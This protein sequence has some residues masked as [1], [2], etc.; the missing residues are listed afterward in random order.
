[1]FRQYLR[2]GLPIF[3]LLMGSL[4]AT[5]YED[6]TDAN[7]A[8][9]WSIYDNT[10]PN[11]T[12]T[13][14]LDSVTNSQVIEL[15]GDGVNNGYML[16]SFSNTSSWNNTTEYILN[17]D[18]K[19]SS[20]YII[21]VRV[22]TING[23]RYLYYTSSEVSYGQAQG[24]S[25]IHFGLGA[26]SK[27]GEWQHISRNLQ[28]DLMQFEPNNQLL[29]T[30]A[31]LVRGSGRFDNIRLSR[32]TNSSN[33][34]LILYDTAGFYGETGKQNA[35]FL[36]NLLGH[37][38]LNVTSKPANEYLANEMDDKRAVF[39]VGTTYDALSNYGVGTAGYVAYQNLFKD[40]ATKNKTIVWMNYNLNVLENNWNSNNLYPLSFAQKFGFTFNGIEQGMF[41]RVLYKNTELYKGVVPFATPGADVANCLDE[42]NNRYACSLESSTVTIQKPNRVKVWASTYSTL[43]GN[44]TPYIVQGENFWFMGDIPFTYMSEEDR[45]LAFADL[46]HDMLEIPHTTSHKALMRLEDVDARTE[47]NDLTVISN[48]MQSTNTPFS[49]A[50]IPIYEDPLGIE[51]GGVATEEN[52]SNSVIG[53]KLKALYESGLVGIVHHGTTHQHHVTV[54]DAPSEINN[55]YNGVS[56]DDF[57]FMRVTQN[58]DGSL[59]Y[60]GPT[61][62]DSAT[63]AIDRMLLGKSVFAQLGITPFAWEAPHYMAGPNHYRAIE[64]VY[65][66]QYARMLYY[67]NE[68]SSDLT[69]KYKFIG[70]F[71]PYVIEKD[72][73]GY[74]IIPEDI[75]NIE[76]VPNPGYRPLFP[77]DT[78]RFAEKLKVV[79]DGVASFFYHPFL[80]DGYLRTIVEG[81]KA[82][83]Y[84]FVPASS[85]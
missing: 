79:R 9:K 55:P 24:S 13:R 51:N 70:Q 60:L 69:K 83:G 47:I 41:N 39:Y 32:S 46:L 33:K 68:Y 2:R 1:M 82:Q 37:F 28:Q 26:V 5:V 74:K 45:Y 36:E 15:L 78:L 64:T 61:G 81:L 40:I 20:D 73:Y 14:V 38:N 6:A 58:A 66:K 27:N 48:Y 22:N 59:N 16:G 53:T 85:L 42:G 65:H 3:L 44:L 72:Y 34:V 4:Y 8:S 67:P 21:Y 18:M 35:I 30:E 29:S 19:F 12:V 11:A 54:N 80:Q 52:L 57:E 63:W 62:N 84:Q 23:E 49:V 76:D 77:S 10:P 43:N 56:G 7:S 17:W 50:T 75:H 25:Y 31:F 71:F